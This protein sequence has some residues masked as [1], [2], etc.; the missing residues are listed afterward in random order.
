MSKN[1]VTVIRIQ[2]LA[3]EIENLFHDLDGETKELF[4]ESFEFENRPENVI[5][6]L[7]VTSSDMLDILTE[8]EQD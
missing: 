6:Q 7:S 5:N 3:D 4:R 2:Q 8:K 1:L